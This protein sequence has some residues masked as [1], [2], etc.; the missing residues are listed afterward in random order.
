MQKN[1]IQKEFYW[2]V[3]NDDNRA[4]DGQKLRDKF[5]QNK[6]CYSAYDVLEGPCTMLELL[7]ALAE[8]CD[9]I[10]YDPEKGDRTAQWF[11]EMLRN[12]ELDRFNDEFYVDFS[13][14]LIIDPILN[15][16]LDRLY[17][18]KWQGRVVSFKRG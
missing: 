11:W 12:L 5:A 7:I 9:D 17:Q 18:K 15:T 16:V 6:A 3:P 8:R 4:V 13:N 10:L 2:T 14:Q 1:C